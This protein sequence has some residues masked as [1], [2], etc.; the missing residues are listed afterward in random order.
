LAWLEHAPDSSRP[1][2]MMVRPRGIM[3]LICAS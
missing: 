2:R 1:R 3:H